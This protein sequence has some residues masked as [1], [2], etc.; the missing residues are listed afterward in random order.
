MSDKAIII[1]PKSGL[2]IFTPLL[3]DSVALVDS[4][5]GQGHACLSIGA[6]ASEDLHA[7]AEQWTIQLVERASTMKRRNEAER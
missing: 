7:I 5:D 1:L 6:L 4:S 2:R 3:P